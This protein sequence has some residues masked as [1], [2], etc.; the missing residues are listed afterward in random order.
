MI[1]LPRQ[2]LRA[3]ALVCALGACL[4]IARAWPKVP[5][6]DRIPTSTA[7]YD[8]RGRLMRLTLSSDQRFRLWQPLARMSR[9]LPQATLLYEDRWFYWHPGV[10]PVALARAAWR[11]L[12]GEGR[13]G[14]STVTMQLARLLYGMNTRT[15]HGKLRQI[16]RALELEA[17]YGKREILEAY[18]NRVPYGGNLEGAEAASL[19]YFGKPAARL[20]LQEAQ[21]LAV[22]PQNPARRKLSA[23]TGSSLD[24]ARQ[25]ML[26]RW[27]AQHPDQAEQAP[28][29]AQSP[30]APNAARLPFR[31]PHVTTMLLAASRNEAEIHSTIDLDL[32]A[33]VERKARDYVAR[34][35]RM[36]IANASVLLLDW[37][38]ME[39]RAVLGSANFHDASIDGQVNGTL[40]KRSPGS[41]LKPF[42]YALAMDQGLIHPMTVLKDA[43]TSFGP[44]SPENFDGRFV[45]PITAQD[46]LIRSRNVPAVWL[47]SQLARP[48]LYEFLKSA[49][50]A[51]MNGERQYGLSLVLGG[52]ELTMEE[53][54]GLYGMLANGGLWRRVTYRA[55]DPARGERGVR[56]LSPQASFAA[57][58]M[59][60]HNPR[61]DQPY[62]GVPARAPI[63]W[64]TGTS[65][66][67]RDAWCVGI[68]GRYALA[69]WL[70]NFDGSANPAL[71]GLTAAAPLFFEIADALQM[72]PDTPIVRRA[73]DRLVRVAVCQDSGDL[74]NAD[75][76]RTV[77]TWFIPGKSPIRVSTL[78]RAAMI[79]LRSG[80]IACPPYDTRYV[81]RE[82]LEY[83]PSDLAHLFAQ[84]GLPRRI[85]PPA[86][87]CAGGEG[88]VGSPPTISSPLRAVTYTLRDDAAMRDAITLHAVADGA[89]H[90]IYWFSDTEYLGRSASGESLAWQHPRPG[91]HRIRA[92]DDQ[93]RSDSREVTVEVRTR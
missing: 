3:A 86:R 17:L 44:F 63:A 71:V 73:P 61:P 39:A 89:V 24:R 7:V 31:A 56:L 10:N 62:A 2:A 80:E 92:V 47:S 28:L 8:D 87:D 23:A 40:A 34:R 14:A 88:P 68:I 77:D 51:R 90:A 36:G 6:A 21:A 20:T 60:E 42:V 37:T 55:D 1:R 83:W 64:K 38:R 27:V 75:C 26:S 91:R 78:H 50:I 84:A 4:G 13:Q 5:L 41:T 67:F 57:L 43:P 15:W 93:G 33:L 25:R 35:R 59:L 9:D 48:N 82:V 58:D 76:P 65:W 54:A 19:F 49:G 32:Q 53:L 69:V 46:A 81:R 72:R 11:T 74:P 30:L 18:L 12:R 79:D 70:G 45:G 16:A 22:I 66:G 85:P 29:L 52:G